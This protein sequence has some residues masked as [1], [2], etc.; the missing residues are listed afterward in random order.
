MSDNN[1]K[2]GKKINKKEYKEEAE[3]ED[4][5]ELSNDKEFINNRESADKKKTIKIQTKANQEPKLTFGSALQKNVKI[6]LINDLIFLHIVKECNC[7]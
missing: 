4:E 7:N 3:E 6:I 1:D 5:K 2:G